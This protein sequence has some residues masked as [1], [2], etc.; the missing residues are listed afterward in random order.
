MPWKSA[1]MDKECKV[2][3]SFFRCFSPRTPATKRDSKS[4]NPSSLTG[5]YKTPNTYFNLVWDTLFI[6]LLVPLRWLIDPGDLEISW[7][8]FFFS[9]SATRRDVEFKKILHIFYWLFLVIL[10]G[11]ILSSKVWTYISYFRLS[12]ISVFVWHKVTVPA[13][14]EH[15][16]LAVDLQD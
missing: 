13:Y 7:L 5:I 1:E 8:T 6:H 2:E 4:E 16:S 12:N 9:R 10:Y 3:D 15:T 11:K 14:W